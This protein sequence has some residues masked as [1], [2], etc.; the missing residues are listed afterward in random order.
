[1]IIFSILHSYVHKKQSRN[2]L[3]NMIIQE[4]VESYS[5]IQLCNK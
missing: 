2:A 3:M 1:M 5:M 4:I